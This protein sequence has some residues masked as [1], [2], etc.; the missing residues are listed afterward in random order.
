MKINVPNTNII[1]TVKSKSRNILGDNVCLHGRLPLNEL[2]K[3]LRG[4][5]PKNDIW[6]RDDIY[7]DTIKRNMTLYEHEL[8]ELELMINKGMKYK[9]AHKWAEMIDGFW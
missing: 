7:N 9:P 3:H 6:M 1:V 2:P 5:I 4:K 8:P